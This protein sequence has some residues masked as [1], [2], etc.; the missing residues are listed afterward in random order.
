[1]HANC[2]AAVKSVGMVPTDL[3]ARRE[4]SAQMRI[5]FSPREAF[6][7]QSTASCFSKSQK[8][9]CDL[10]VLIGSIG[11]LPVGMRFEATLSDW[12]RLKRKSDAP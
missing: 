6:S 12:R 10:I 4:S 2:V 8:C 1:M 7:A 11:A 9:K 5:V 3:N